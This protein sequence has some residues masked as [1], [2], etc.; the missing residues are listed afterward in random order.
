MS[1]YGYKEAHDLLY[2]E[3][4]DGGSQHD[5]IAKAL[6]R[7]YSAGLGR[8]EEIAR[9]FESEWT[10]AGSIAADQLAEAIERERRSHEETGR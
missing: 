4:Y 2:P 5:R 6:Q 10:G 1:T 7:A 3:K 8:A 9:G